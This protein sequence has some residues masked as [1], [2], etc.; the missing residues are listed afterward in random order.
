MLLSEERH[1][2]EVEIDFVVEFQ[3]SAVERARE[4]RRRVR[5]MSS[6]SPAARSLHNETPY[7]TSDPA[8]AF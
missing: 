6:C 3:I 8:H 5:P 2:V 7:V 1:D 4:R